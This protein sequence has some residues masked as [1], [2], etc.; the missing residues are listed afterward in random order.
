MAQVEVKGHGVFY[1][2]QL[3]PAL[4][5]TQLDFSPVE[6]IEAADDITETFFV[7]YL[8]TILMNIEIR[9][10]A[11]AAIIAVTIC[12]ILCPG[13]FLP[14]VAVI[15]TGIVRTIIATGVKKGALAVSASAYLFYHLLRLQ[16]RKSL[17]DRD[18]SERLIPNYLVAGMDISY[19]KITSYFIVGAYSILNASKLLQS[20]NCFLT[21]SHRQ[22][23]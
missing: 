8:N 9:P 5:Q 1:F 19:R 16:S 13:T 18:C 15:Q 22:I 6:L 2:N 3:A 10:P 12:C 17:P 11:K 21:I 23:T 20:S 14:S 7:I 4:V